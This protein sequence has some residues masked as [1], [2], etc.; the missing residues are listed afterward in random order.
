M[1]RVCCIG[2][3]AHADVDVAQELWERALELQ[4]ECVDAMCNLA[5]LLQG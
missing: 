2:G 1:E 5:V 4:P 3:A